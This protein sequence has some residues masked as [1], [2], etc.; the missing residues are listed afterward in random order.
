MFWKWFEDGNAFVKDTLPGG[1]EMSVSVVV[2]SVS[3]KNLKLY[4][5]LE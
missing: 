3:Y 2:Q 1:L 5:N 4:N